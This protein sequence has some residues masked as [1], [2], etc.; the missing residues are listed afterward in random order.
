MVHIHCTLVLLQVVCSFSAEMQG[1]VKVWF[2]FRVA[3]NSE[4]CLETSLTGVSAVV[5][6]AFLCASLLSTHLALM[7]LSNMLAN[8]AVWCVA[9]V[10]LVFV[11]SKLIRSQC[12]QSRWR[13]APAVLHPV[14]LRRNISLISPSRLTFKRL[15]L[16]LCVRVCVS[17]C[18]HARACQ[19][20]EWACKLKRLEEGKKGTESDR[21]TASLSLSATDERV[22]TIRTASR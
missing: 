19:K 18:A 8:L 22:Q 4:T 6:S 2:I 13:S 7:H 14:V 10:Q 21:A 3:H 12:A 1:K 11:I 5:S 20:S 15:N 9:A 16:E 17:V